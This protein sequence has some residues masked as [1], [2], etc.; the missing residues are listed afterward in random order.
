[1]PFGQMN[2]PDDWGTYYSNCPHCGIRYH[3]SEGCA[4]V[5]C[6][7]CGDPQNKDDYDVEWICNNCLGCDHCGEVKEE[8]H[9]YF[10]IDLKNED[11]DPDNP[12]T[13][14]NGDLECEMICPKCLNKL[15]NKDYK[16]FV[17]VRVE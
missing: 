10:V 16:E 4:C 2:V 8:N 6:E 14:N 15:K 3:E 13:R 7:R 17:F 11:F 5:N 1:M 12:P 9:R